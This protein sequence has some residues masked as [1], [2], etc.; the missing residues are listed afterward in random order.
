MTS[1]KEHFYKI[2]SQKG[3][4]TLVADHAPKTYWALEPSLSEFSE[5]RLSF[6]LKRTVSITDTQGVSILPGGVLPA[7]IGITFNERGQASGTGKGEVKL[8]WAKPADNEKLEPSETTF[9][10]K[11]SQLESDDTLLPDSDQ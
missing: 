9:T 6:V 4:N 5:K 8:Q 2:I 7:K 10:F 1:N 11:K 3:E